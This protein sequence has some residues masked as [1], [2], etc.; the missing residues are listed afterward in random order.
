MD[1]SLNPALCQRARDRRS[2]PRATFIVRHREVTGVSATPP[3]H[4]VAPLHRQT[5]MPDRSSSSA[6]QPARIASVVTAVASVVLLMWLLAEHW[7]TFLEWKAQAGFWPF[8]AGLALLPLI[9]IPTTPLF[10]LAGAGFELRIALI[11]CAGAIAVNLILSWWLAHRWM[12]TPL[13]RLL[14]RFRCRPSAAGTGN[15]LALLLLVR[16]TP[17]LPATLRN[18]GAALVE[19][20]FA[21]YFVVSWSATALY[22]VGLIVLGDSLR[23]ASWTEAGIALALLVAVASGALWFRK[24]QG[25]KEWPGPSTR[26]QE[27]SDGP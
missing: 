26:Q 19:V 7:E 1:A 8:F 14:E 16:L 25:R 10:V 24:V 15:P 12:R 13:T 5:Q 4:K 17:G 20:P 3:T 18:Y 21:L 27:P 6:W 9:G 2:T 22:A 23:N 11:G